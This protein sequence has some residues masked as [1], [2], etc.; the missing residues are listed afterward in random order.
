M[1]RMSKYVVVQLWIILILPDHFVKLE[2]GHFDFV[3]FEQRY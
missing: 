1:A 3:S 2:P